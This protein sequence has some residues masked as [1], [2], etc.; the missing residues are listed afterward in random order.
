MLDCRCFFRVGFRVLC[1]VLLFFRSS[2]LCAG[3]VENPVL[4]ADLPDPDV[5]RVG[6][7][8]YMVTTTMH[9]MPGAPVMMSEDL[10]NWRTVSYLFDSLHDTSRYDMVGGTVYGR[11]QWATSLRYHDGLFYAL[12]SPNDVPYRSKVY[13]TDDPERGWRLLGCL[14]HFHDASLFFDDDGRVY[15]F[16]GTGRLRELRADLSDVKEG[17][18]DTVVFER[19]VSETG[20]LE[21]SRV[22]KRNGRYYLFMVSWPSGG[23]RREVCYRADDILGPYEKRVVL[24]SEFGGFSFVGQGTV[25]DDGDGDWYGLIFQDRGGVGRVLTLM[26]CRW[27]DDWPMLGDED[28]CVPSV[29]ELPGADDGCVGVV[30]S[31]CF[32]LDCLSLQWQWNHNPL[33]DLWSLSDR[34]G[35]LRLCAAGVSDNIFVARNTLTTRMEGP[36]CSG[37]VFVDFSGMS[38]GDCAGFAAFNGDACLLSVNFAGGE[39]W[40]VQSEECVLL[41]EDDKSVVDVERVENERVLLSQ[42][43]LWLRIDADFRAGEDWAFCYYSYDGRRWTQLGKRFKMRFDYRRLF[44]GTRF[45]VFNYSGECRGGC[46]DV[47]CF[48]YLHPFDG[49]GGVGS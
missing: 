22:V 33:D 42:S 30:E 7:R 27:V 12:F 10:V 36:T 19:D 43:E 15:V 44:M 32:D 24:C 1:W 47:D 28:G 41:S 4:W 16:Y 49:V 37:R 38:D 45:A 2:V 34:P 17:G 23:P 8:F 20:L 9:L 26:P 48:V 14:P 39:F 31:D 6:D 5:I 18:V 46:V 35:F 11:G 3:G 29:V 21:G 13:V 40:L 25:V